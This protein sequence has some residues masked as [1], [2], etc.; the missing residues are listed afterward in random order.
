MPISRLCKFLQYVH[1]QRSGI[2]TP[3]QSTSQQSGIS[4]RFCN[5]L[6][7]S[8]ERRTRINQ[9]TPASLNGY[10]ST[11][12]WN[13]ELFFDAPNAV[14]M[15][16]QGHQGTVQ[17]VPCRFSI[18]AT[19]QRRPC[20]STRSKKRI[21]GRS[22][23]WRYR[24]IDSCQDPAGC[25]DKQRIMIWRILNQMWVKNSNMKVD[26]ELPRLCCHHIWSTCSS[27]E[28]SSSIASDRHSIP[29]KTVCDL[30]R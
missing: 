9:L 23:D 29:V 15:M 8:R 11:D 21:S 22:L 10:Q 26:Q 13:I 18:P 7:C 25:K 28:Q 3:E 16:D 5:H 19:V 20:Y 2:R 24:S 30:P 1:H 6:M 17:W 12:T 4:K 27:H 14:Q